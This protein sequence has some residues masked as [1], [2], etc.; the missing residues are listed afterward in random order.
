[1]DRFTTQVSLSLTL[2]TLALRVLL[3]LITPNLPAERLLTVILCMEINRAERRKRKKKIKTFV[4][5]SEVFN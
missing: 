2:L 5:I 1:M 4:N 3:S